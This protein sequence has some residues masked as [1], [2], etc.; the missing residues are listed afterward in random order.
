MANADIANPHDGAVSNPLNTSPATVHGSVAAVDWWDARD[1]DGQ[2][3]YD[4]VDGNDL[5]K[6]AA[7]FQL[8]GVPFMGTRVVFRDGVQRKGSEY[9]DDYASLELQVAPE[10]V[11]K[12][13]LVRIITR[14]QSLKV[15]PETLMADPDE[16]LVLND[17]STGIYRQIVQYLVMKGHVTLPD[18]EEEGEKGDS[19]FDLPRSQWLTGADAATEGIDIKLR[20][21]RG[22]R[23]SDYT[24]DY[25]GN[26]TAR[27]WYIA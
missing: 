13:S 15:P 24:N 26:E 7:L 27:T 4:E 5:L 8:V 19:I 25:T 1:E 2:A 12:H 22:L 11:I 14:R 10:R 18:G 6:D 21:S 16:Q 20:C 23:F 9:R 3:L 17:G